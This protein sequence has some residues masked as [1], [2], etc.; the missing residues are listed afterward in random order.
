MKNLLHDLYADVCDLFKVPATPFLGSALLALAVIILMIGGTHWGVFGGLRYLGDAINRGFGLGRDLGFVEPLSPMMRQPFLISDGMI[1][2]GAMASSL[3]SGHFRLL[4][5]PPAEY[6]TGAWGGILM[7]LGAS[8]AGGCTVGGFFIPLTFFSPSGWIMLLGLMLGSALGVR[9]LLWAMDVFPWGKAPP[10]PGVTQR[11]HSWVGWFMISVIMVW[12]IFLYRNGDTFGTLGLT[13]MT[14]LFLGIVLQRTRLC[15]S[16]AI[17]EPFMTGDGQHAKAIML[18][19]ALVTPPAAMLLNKG[20]LAP[21][22]SIPPSFW[23]GSLTGGVLFGVGMVFA[24]GCATSTLWRLGEGNLKMVSTLFFFCWSGSVSSAL[25]AKSGWTERSYDL[26]FLNAI[27]AV[28]KLGFQAW[29]PDLTWGWGISLLITY[30]I[31][32]LWYALIRYNERT[33]R[34]TVF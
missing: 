17:R 29:L 18:L 14:A 32:L 12:G 30:G 33:E 7:G 2:L 3:I 8:L 23:L 6:W 20:F 25:L 22:G 11:W 5:P 34:F 4:R 9:L 31:L 10:S 26:D 27:P 28:T 19:I 21:Y 15:F 16:K 13:V 1:I 24:G